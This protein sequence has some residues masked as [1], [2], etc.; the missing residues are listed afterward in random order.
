M[1]MM[2]GW[3]GN[4]RGRSGPGPDT[5][6][7]HLTVG[8]N[9]LTP[10]ARGPLDLGHEVRADRDTRPCRLLPGWRDAGSS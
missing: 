4:S 6:I 2:H 10:G 3:P 9:T 8:R 1:P 7:R 5:A